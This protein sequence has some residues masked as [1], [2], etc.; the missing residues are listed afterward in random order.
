[1][2]PEELKLLLLYIDASILAASNKPGT[3][4]LHG[5]ALDIKKQLMALTKEGE[6]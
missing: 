1:M 3:A 2:K 6:K 4:E 5:E